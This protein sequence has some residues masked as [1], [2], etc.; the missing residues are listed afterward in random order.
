MSS[1]NP[2]RTAR[3]RLGK[4][5]PPKLDLKNPIH[6]PLPDSPWPKRIGLAAAFIGA[7]LALAWQRGAFGATPAETLTPD[8]S[9]TYPEPEVH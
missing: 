3:D 7:A 4:K 8:Q 1:P 9:I 2:A 6:R 5:A